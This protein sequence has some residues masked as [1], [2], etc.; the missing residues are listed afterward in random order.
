MR[1]KDREIS[2]RE[3]IVS[4]L[5]EAEVCRVALQAEPAP[6]IV[7]LSYGFSWKEKLEIYFHSADAGRKLELIES[8]NNVGFEIDCGQELVTG[9]D[10]CSWGMKFKSLIGTGRIYMLEDK[11]ERNE[12]LSVIL[13][14]YGHEGNPV[15]NG[16]IFEKTK[17]LRLVVDKITGKQRK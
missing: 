15:Y 2:D 13:K 5:E 9:E 6:Y 16:S 4:V 12:A 8:N 7:P 11:D 1:R 17:V 10:A 3:Q 14:H